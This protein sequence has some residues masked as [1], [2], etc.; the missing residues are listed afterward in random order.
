M[1]NDKILQTPFSTWDEGLSVSS[2]L[3]RGTATATA[4]LVKLF[5]LSGALSGAAK[6]LL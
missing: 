4:E 6:T 5:G 1:L 3:D 2:T